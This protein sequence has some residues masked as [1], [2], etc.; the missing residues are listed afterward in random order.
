MLLAWRL[1]LAHHL[2][3]WEQKFRRLGEKWGYPQAWFQELQTYWA[4]PRM[5]LWEFHVRYTLKRM[6]AEKVLK[7]HMTEAEAHTFYTTSDYMMLRNVVHRRHAA[8]RRVLA[9][10]RGDT[11]ALLE[12]GCG[13]AP[14]SAWL[15]KRR[16]S[17][18][19]AL[20]DL[21]SPHL[22]YAR[23]RLGAADVQWPSYDVVTAIDVFEHLAN[24]ITSARQLVRCLKRGGAMHFNIH[25]NPSANDL[26]LATEEQ[27][28]A[29]ARYLESALHV[30]WRNG[31]Y[32]IARKP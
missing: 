13:T 21:D 2:D 27:L 1:T 20:A 3:W 7:P 4:Q 17:W 19:Y 22:R 6:D 25:R 24:P 32:C 30:V 18:T 12:Y 15:A 9:T 23:W 5:E 29:T 16:P 26:D 8:W 28:N 31:E 10:M 14:V 11:G